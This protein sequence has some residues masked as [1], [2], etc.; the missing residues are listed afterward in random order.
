M[1]NEAALC[2][3]E[4]VVSEPS[5]VDVGMIFGTGF[6]PFRGG[7]LCYADQ[8][9]IKNIVNDLERFAQDLKAERFEPCSLLKDLW[10]QN[11]GFYDGHIE[12]TLMAEAV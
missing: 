10:N 7:L 4:G 5:D 12:K 8:I 9:G 11:K 3:S 1:I 6:P 2:L